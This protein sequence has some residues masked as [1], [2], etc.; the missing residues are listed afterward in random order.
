[1][2]VQLNA[3]QTA[4]YKQNEECNDHTTNLVLLAAVSGDGELLDAAISLHA[5]RERRG[6][7]DWLLAPIRDRIEEQLKPVF[8]K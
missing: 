1:M 5:A 2:L 7:I 8:A 6:A 4:L 3:E